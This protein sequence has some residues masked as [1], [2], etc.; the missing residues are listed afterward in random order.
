MIA[1]LLSGL[2]GAIDRSAS[3]AEMDRHLEGIEAIMESHFRFEERSLLNIL[4]HLDL[5]A[6]PRDVLGPL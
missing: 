6:D 2:Q 3:A 1:H 4:E 5:I